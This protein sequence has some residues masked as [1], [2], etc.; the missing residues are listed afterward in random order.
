MVFVPYPEY[1]AY[2]LGDKSNAYLSGLENRMHSAGGFAPHDDVQ[3]LMR[4]LV[5]SEKLP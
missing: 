4:E 3:E 1:L 5:R 2:R